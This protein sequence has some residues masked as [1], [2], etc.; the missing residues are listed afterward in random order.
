M[1]RF[2][3]QRVVLPL[4][5][6]LYMVGDS[7]EYAQGVT[8]D[9]YRLVAYYDST[10]CSSCRLKTLY[11]WGGL[12]DSVSSS[13]C[14]VDF[15]F[16]FNVPTQRMEEVKTTLATYARNLPVYLDTIGVFERMNPNLPRLSRMRTF[17]LN[18]KDTVVLIGNPVHNRHVA[19]IMWNVVR[20]NIQ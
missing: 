19:D 17:L 16:V 4:D 1:A 2:Y 11:E 20:E 15:Y 13:G 14:K 3:G 9:G 8:A 5:S 10:E 18:R 7:T 6:M 12:I